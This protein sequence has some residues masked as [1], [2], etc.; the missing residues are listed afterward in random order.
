MNRKERRARKE[1]KGREERGTRQPAELVVTDESLL[2][3]AKEA[4]RLPHYRRD[5]IPIYREYAALM[6]EAVRKLVAPSGLPPSRIAFHVVLERFGGAFA[7]PSVATATS[8]V[9]FAFYKFRPHRVVW[10]ISEDLAFA[11]SNTDPPVER[12]TDELMANRFRLPYPGM[13]LV[14]PPVYDLQDPESGSH[15]VQGIYLAEDIVLTTQQF[16]D[17]VAGRPTPIVGAAPAIIASAIG[18]CKGVLP[19]YVLNDTTASLTL[20]PVTR[21]GEVEYLTRPSA[22]HKNTV[23]LVT[24]FL[25]ALHSGY[26]SVEQKD[27]SSRRQTIGR[28]GI[29]HVLPRSYTYVQ[30]SEKVRRDNAEKGAMRAEDVRHVRAHLV[31]GHW[32][33]YWVLNPEGRVF[34]ET[35]VSRTGKTEHKVRIWLLPYYV[36]DP[37]D[38]LPPKYKSNENPNRRRGM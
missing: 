8:Y 36:G 14:L 19:G 18:E 31:R 6:G 34:T 23:Q 28:G 22:G 3:A 33:S 4:C 30:L 25:W 37:K 16:D 17:M 12:F 32:H 27:S 26:L 10:L 35:R 11:L 29:K 13:Y 1:R 24:N 2:S 21:G 9:D 20:S 15:K 38:A 5:E 7:S